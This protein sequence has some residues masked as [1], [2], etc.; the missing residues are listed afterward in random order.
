MTIKKLLLIS[1]SG[2]VSLGCFATTYYLKPDGND[3]N[4]GKSE[5]AAFKTINKAVS[6][7]HNQGSKDEL[8]ILPGEYAATSL[9][10]MAG[11]YTEDFA[12]AD[13]IRSSTRNPADVVIYGNGTF[14]LL[15]LASCVVVDG[16]TFSNGVA[17][18]AGV[19]GGVRVGSSTTTYPTLLTN[20]VITC[21]SANFAGKAAGG[22]YVYGGGKMTDC[23]VESCSATTDDGAAGVFL[24]NSSKEPTIEH[25][26][27]RDCSGTNYSDG[28]TCAGG[29]A[30]A[31][32]RGGSEK[33]VECVISNCT[34]TVKA[35]V[36]IFRLGPLPWCLV[37]RL[38]C[39]M[40]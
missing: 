18:A 2:M 25:T 26:I 23:I 20:C 31:G 24:N 16:I 1:V 10:S 12:N 33:I 39:A 7:L 8:V 35:A 5:S 29:I 40:R 38:R 21:C 6:Q 14:N 36:P 22:A 37:R 19:G 34:A 28:K 13:V 9:L 15:N 3:S 32:S 27:V 4:D 17:K 30:S 11:Q